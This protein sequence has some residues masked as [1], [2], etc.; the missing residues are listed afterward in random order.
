MTSEASS[1]RDHHLDVICGVMI[2]YMTY[3]HYVDVTAWQEVY[4]LS[5][6]F[7]PFFM[8]WFYF[9]GGIFFSIGEVNRRYVV[10][11]FKRLIIPTLGFTLFGLL[12]VFERYDTLDRLLL[13]LG[14]GFLKFGATP[15][16]LPLWYLT[17]LFLVRL[18]CRWVVRS[19]WHAIV[20]SVVAL[21]IATYCHSIG[22][23]DYKVLVE[24]VALG[25]IFFT[26]GFLLRTLQYNRW[27]FLLAIV[28]ACLSFLLGISYVHMVCNELEFGHYWH[29]F[30]MS[31]SGIIIVNNIGRLIAVQGCEFMAA[32][33][34]NSLYILGAHMP[35]AH[36]VNRLC[37]HC[38]IVS[39]GM[40]RMLVVSVTTSV[41]MCLLFP[42]FK[43]TRLKVLLGE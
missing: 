42:L 32:L 28:F 23:T 6:K 5:F 21:L 39:V 20:L 8:P 3:I 36:L 35:I 38:D 9:K 13:T 15:I 19:M 22:A 17:A 33:G 18:V 14:G 10:N 43:R 41:I 2:L 30:P 37:E 26:A 4:T 27:I 34:R 25:L 7:I 29:F 1:H 16:N 24:R 12:C 11:N 31:L 40:E